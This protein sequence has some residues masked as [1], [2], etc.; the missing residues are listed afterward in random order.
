M[1]LR[2]QF[3]SEAR[4]ERLKS[5]GCRISVEGKGRWSDNVF[6]EGLWRSVK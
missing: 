1:D 6:I 2:A 5:S 4:L 3:A